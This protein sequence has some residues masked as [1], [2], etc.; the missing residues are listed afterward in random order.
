MSGYGNIHLSDNIDYGD[1]CVTEVFE[2]TKEKQNSTG[3]LTLSGFLFCSS[4]ADVPTGSK[5]NRRDKS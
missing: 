2:N 3:Q 1:Y 4:L 5:V